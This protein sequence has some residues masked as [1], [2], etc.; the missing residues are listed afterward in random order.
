MS[1]HSFGLEGATACAGIP[2]LGCDTSE[3]IRM[4]KTEQASSSL[5]E[6]KKNVG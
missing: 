4:I 1:Y 2:G 3:Q 5:C 6:N